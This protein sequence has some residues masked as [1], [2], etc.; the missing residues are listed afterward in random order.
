MM[1]GHQL[2]DTE[3]LKSVW[4]MPEAVKAT[5]SKVSRMSSVI[6]PAWRKR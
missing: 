1:Y 3:A 6:L 5:S 2:E 4:P